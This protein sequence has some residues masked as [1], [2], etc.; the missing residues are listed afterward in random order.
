MFGVAGIETLVRDVVEECCAVARVEGISLP[1]EWTWL[2]ARTVDLHSG[3]WWLGIG[4]QRPKACPDGRTGEGNHRGGSAGSKESRVSS[5][6]RNQ[7]RI[8]PPLP[9]ATRCV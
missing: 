7:P 3:R 1:A 8:P 2:L 9:A 5:R 4:L 6:V